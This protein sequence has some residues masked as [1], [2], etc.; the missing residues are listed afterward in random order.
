MIESEYP[1]RNPRSI[2]KFS[3]KDNDILIACCPKNKK[4]ILKRL[5]DLDAKLWL[6]CDGRTELKRIVKR[7]SGQRPEITLTKI[8]S[9]LKKWSSARLSLLQI[10]Q[11]TI[12]RKDSRTKDNLLRQAAADI[13]QE[14]KSVSQLYRKIYQDQ[15]DYHLSKIRSARKQFSDIERTVSYLF[16]FRH[17]ALRNKSYGQVFRERLSSIKPIKNYSRF[18]EIGAGAGY[19]ASEF[20]DSLREH[21]QEAY[22]TCKYSFL[23][24]SSVLLKAQRKT[25][26]Q[27]KRNIASLLS[28]AERQLPF[29]DNTFDFIILNEVIADFS[30]VRLDR[31][32]I[33]NLIKKP[34][35]ITSNGSFGK[36]LRFIHDYQIPIQDAPRQFIFSLGVIRL[37]EELKRILAPDGLCVIIEYGDLNSYPKAVKL[38]G[39]KEY[40]IHFGHLKWIAEK[41]GFKVEIIN[42]LNFLKFRKDFKTIERCSLCLL[43]KLLKK[44]DK[45]GISEVLFKKDIKKL[46]GKKYSDFDNIKYIDLEKGV[47]DFRLQ[48]FKVAVLKKIG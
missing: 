26:S 29:R 37:L 7:L 1:C 30:V 18:L 13:F 6:G 14:T 9:I 43:R 44:K 10:K 34:N 19:L 11:R 33:L 32:K 48:D 31:D 25:N 15:W 39:H 21:N 40:S 23:D 28:N 38:K 41:A 24:L 35:F 3:N 47:L 20:L 42:L 36:A 46:L 22:R 2:W 16:R 8:S 4:P 12:K 5:K 45:C 27:H 17:P